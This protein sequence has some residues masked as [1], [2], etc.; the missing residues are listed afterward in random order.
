MGL[1]RGWFFI[2]CQKEKKFVTKIMSI[3]VTLNEVS[4]HQTFQ[5]VDGPWITFWYQEPI[6]GHNN[7]KHWIDDHNNSK[8]DS[9]DLVRLYKPN[10]GRIDDILSFWHS[11]RYKLMPAVLRPRIAFQILSWN[12]GENWRYHWLRTI[13]MMKGTLYRGWSSQIKV[14]YPA[15]LDR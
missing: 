8:H 12:L 11:Q 10:V 1:R 4:T 15:N 7:A 14:L 3:H 13:L 2:H 9:I 5:I 6:S